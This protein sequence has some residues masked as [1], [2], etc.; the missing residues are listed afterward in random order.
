MDEGLNELLFRGR[1]AAR[2]GDAAEAR[3]YLQWVLDRCEGLSQEKLEALYW[4]SRIATDPAEKRRYLEDVLAAEPFNTRA[5]RDLAVL[6]GRIN[7][8]EQID[9]DRP[10]ARKTGGL[11]QLD[12]AE[13]RRFTCPQCGGKLTYTPDGQAL[14]CEYCESRQALDS[15]QGGGISAGEDFLVSMATGRGHQV[16]VDTQAVRCGGCGAE[17]TLPPSELTASCPF[18]GSSHV[19]SQEARQLILPGSLIP[20]AISGREALRSLQAGLSAARIQP[21]HTVPAPQGVYLPAWSFSLGGTAVWRGYLEV[22]DQRV[23]ASGEEAVWQTGLLVPAGSRLA[24]E[25]ARLLPT[26][27]PTGCVPYDE[28]Y[29]VDWPAETYQVSVGDASLDARQQALEKIRRDLHQVSQPDVQDMQISTAGMS[30]VSHQ[31]WLLPVWVA[32][33]SEDGMSRQALV[34]GQN[35]KLDQPGP[36]GLLGWLGGLFS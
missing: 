8:A 7:A 24:A 31:L 16:P 2:C 10:P 32:T 30:V 15:D 27:D 6:D 18:C 14:T 26:Y 28:R 23:P 20:F 5:R 21:D 36:G 11:Y 22:N 3:F 35:G 17:F 19:I 4:M 13:A 9:P 29:L 34:N 33:Y 25:F 12:S 1:T